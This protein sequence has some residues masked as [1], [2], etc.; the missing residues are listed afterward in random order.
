[1]ADNFEDFRELLKRAFAG[2]EEAARI[3]VERY[4]GRVRRGLRRCFGRNHPLRSLFDSADFTQM[5]WDSFLRMQG[6]VERFDTAEDLVAFLVRIAQN[7]VSSQ[8]RRSEA[9]KRGGPRGHSPGDSAA[10]VPDIADRAV[11]ALDWIASQDQLERLLEG[12][13]ATHREMFRLQFQGC[14]CKEIGERL[15]LGEGHVRRVLAEIVEEFAAQTM[16][17]QDLPPT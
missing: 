17:P 11:P 10:G 12:R 15:G 3:L 4:E 13:P 16:P 8:S 7:K 14:S 1:M 5:V 2:S 6:E 9:A